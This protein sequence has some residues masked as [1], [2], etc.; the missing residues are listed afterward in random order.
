MIKKLITLLCC[1]LVATAAWAQDKSD[2]SDLVLGLQGGVGYAA[3]TG[4]LHDAI[5]GSAIFSAGVTADYKRLRFKADFDYSQPS[6]NNPNLYNKKDEH[7][8][9]AM[10]NGNSNATQT[11]LGLQLGYKVFASRRVSITP[12]A[13]V[14]FTRLSWTLNEIKWQQDKDDVWYFEVTDSHDK[15]MG[16][17]SWIASIDIDIKLGERLTTDPFFLNHRYSRL[18]TSLRIT[19]WLSGGK[20][21][22]FDP[23]ASGLYIG[24]TIRI[25]GTMQSL[26]F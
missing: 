3:T 22:E 17:T 2:E 21:K 23:S 15:R 8:F 14:Y 18:G 11:A 10:I 9:D 20:F 16:K 6:F 24:A 12:A 25:T 7:G 5:N 13:G 1:T 19:P 4:S 26:G